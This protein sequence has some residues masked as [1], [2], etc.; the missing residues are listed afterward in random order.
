MAF[1]RS[2]LTVVQPLSMQGAPFALTDKPY[3]CSSAGGRNS[4][5]TTVCVTTLLTCSGS[6]KLIAE[7]PALS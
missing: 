7:F 4:P 3:S 6:F 1:N 2:T 5:V